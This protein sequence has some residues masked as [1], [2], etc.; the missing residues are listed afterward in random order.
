MLYLNMSEQGDIGDLVSGVSS[1]TSI[2]DLFLTD[3]GLTGRTNSS[4]ID[5]FRDVAW[6]TEDMGLLEMNRSGSRNFELESKYFGLSGVTYESTREMPREQLQ[7]D[8]SGARP[9]TFG[10]LW[11]D[12]V[13]ETLYWRGCKDRK[14]ATSEL[15][16]EGGRNNPMRTTAGSKED[17]FILDMAQRDDRYLVVCDVFPIDFEFRDEEYGEFYKLGVPT[18]FPYAQAAS[19]A[20]EEVPVKEFISYNITVQNS[21]GQSVCAFHDQSVSVRPDEHK[22]LHPFRRTIEGSPGSNAAELRDAARQNDDMNKLKKVWRTQTPSLG[23]WP[24]GLVNSQCIV[25]LEKV[26]KN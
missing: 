8:W 12:T 11:G 18:S 7:S 9:V 16:G 24:E 2:L 17:R 23:G 4:S 25:G 3:T 6:G 20:F 1:K 22:Y 26:F 10:A 19:G 5:F 14:G 15:D 13:V 21:C